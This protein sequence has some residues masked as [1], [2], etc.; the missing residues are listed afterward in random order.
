MMEHVNTLIEV[1]KVLRY[2]PHFKDAKFS[3]ITAKRNGSTL[4]IELSRGKES[5]ELELRAFKNISN[6]RGE[7]SATI[8]YLMAEARH[9]RYTDMAVDEI[10]AVPQKVKEKVS[11]NGLIP[12]EVR[13]SVTSERVDLGKPSSLRVDTALAMLSWVCD[14]TD[15]NSLIGVDNV[16]EA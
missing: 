3:G 7:D 15:S 5:L 4:T 14:Q 11:P 13:M 2:N 8:L 6:I 9:V 1:S 16:S 12:E 10:C